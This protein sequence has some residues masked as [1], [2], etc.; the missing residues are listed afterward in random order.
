MNYV[1]CN[2][3]RGWDGGER[4]ENTSYYLWSN[5]WYRTISSYDQ[6]KD[7]SG[8]TIY[9]DSK[10][11]YSYFVQESGGVQFIELCYGFCLRP[12]LYSQW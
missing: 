8:S 7:G 5:E 1:I 9:L 3:S 6:W 2:R 12:R 4:E 11:I 10:G